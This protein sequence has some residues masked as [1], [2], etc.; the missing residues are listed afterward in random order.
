MTYS[1][2]RFDHGKQLTKTS[3]FEDCYRLEIQI[4]VVD[5][6]NGNLLAVGIIEHY[7]DTSVSIKGHRY[8]REKYEFYI[9]Y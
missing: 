8:S 5:P 9:H 2:K 7:D 1:V 6:E 3:D 4:A